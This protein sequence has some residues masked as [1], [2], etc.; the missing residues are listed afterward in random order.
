MFY[1]HQVNSRNMERYLLVV[2]SVCVAMLACFLLGFSHS[3]LASVSD[4]VMG[5][6][7]IANFIVNFAKFVEWPNSAFESKSSP[8]IVCI[9]GDDPL[10][11]VLD[12]KVSNKK[13][14]KR[15]FIVERI[16][17]GDIEAIKK[18]HIGFLG[19]SEVNNVNELAN[20]LVGIPVLTVS[21]LE[22]FAK[23]GGMIG[24]VGKGRKVRMQINKTRINKADLKASEK[25][26]KIGS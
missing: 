24:I 6:K 15:G 20:S 9:V 10:Q 22:G 3:G 2:R 11:D 14:K 19:P 12:K 26:L 7:T 21:D 5:K 18:C 1:T 8:F 4:S 23:A 16:A 25:L 13:V 17:S